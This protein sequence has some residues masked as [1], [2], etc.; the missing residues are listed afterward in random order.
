[1]N[2]IEADSETSGKYAASATPISALSCLHGALGGGD[3]GTPF[4]ERRGQRDRNFRN[5]AGQQ[6]RADRQLRRRPADQHGD[7]VLE[8]GALHAD[9]EFLRFD[10]QNLRLR[11]RHVG[12]GRSGRGGWTVAG[13]K[14]VQRDLVGFAEL[15]GGAVQEVAQ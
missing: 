13:F 5:S 2:W 7:G 15:G 6:A 9:A 12:A 10:G 4:Q 3:I 11:Q 8:L 14:F 1:M